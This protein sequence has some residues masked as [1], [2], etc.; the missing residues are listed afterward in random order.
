M[1]HCLDRERQQRCDAR[2]WGVRTLRRRDKEIIVVNKTMKLLVLGYGRHGKD[3]VCEILKDK[4]NLDFQSSSEFC[5]KLFIYNELK[6][7]YGYNNYQECYTDRH[8]H[9]AEWFDMIHDYCKHDLARLGRNIFEEHDIYCGLRNKDEMSA[10]KAQGIYDY[11][12]WVDRSQHLAPED[13]SSMNITSDMADFVIDNNGTVAELNHN[14]ELFM[15]Q[16]SRAGE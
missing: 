2:V 14:V 15:T 9:R 11:S 7:K 8:N 10:M 3:T 12:V 13:G 16:I 4:F 1:R 5:A 6:D